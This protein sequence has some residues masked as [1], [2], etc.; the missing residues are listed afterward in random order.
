MIGDQ[1]WR[2][3]VLCVELGECR[4][5][6]Y[7]CNHTAEKNLCRGSGVPQTPKGIEA[8]NAASLPANVGIRPVPASGFQRFSVVYGLADHHA[9]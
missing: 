7:P 6:N 8:E 3:L 9:D 2:S 5:S 4:A 1:V